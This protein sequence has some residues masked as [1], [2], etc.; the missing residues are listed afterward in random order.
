MP[1]SP[2]KKSS[3]ASL[4]SWRT[5]MRQ[6][7]A[8]EKQTVFRSVKER[9]QVKARA[10]ALREQA[11]LKHRSERKAEI[12]KA[13]KPKKAARK[14]RIARAVDTLTQA[15]YSDNAAPASLQGLAR[16]TNQEMPLTGLNRGNPGHGE[17]VGGEMYNLAEELAT[18]ARKKGGKDEIQ[19]RLMMAT[20]T[21]AYEGE[22]AADKRHMQ[23]VR[24]IHE[25]NTDKVV[26]AALA[27]FECDPRFRNG[28]D[29]A[30]MLSG[31]TLARIVDALNRAGYT[32]Q[33]R[34]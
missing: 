3:K 33:G 17:L 28:F 25:A 32:A 24:A 2:K 23:A 26:C 22:R 11:N 6:A 8:L 30:V 12:A 29:P 18:L 13:S 14:K 31:Y 16:L 19:S 27:V 10:A 15:M 21:A 34:I 20:A 7:E 4:P 9:K 1:K 5:L